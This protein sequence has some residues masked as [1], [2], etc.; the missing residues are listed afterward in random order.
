MNRISS[1]MLNSSALQNLQRSQSDM[2]EAQRKTASGK[3][4]DDLKGYGKDTQAIVSMDRTRAKLESHIEA[5]KELNV[6]LN[7]QDAQIG[8]AADAVADLRE[9]LTTS[10]ALGD[11]TEVMAYVNSAFSDVKSAFNTTFNGSY[12]FG[13]TA[14]NAEPIQADSLADMAANPLTDSINQDGSEVRIRVSESRV[15]TAAPLAKDAATD[16]MNLLR[17]LQ[18]FEDG[19]DGPFTDNPSEA[20]K[21]AIQ[22][23]ILGLDSVYEGML[24]VQSKNGQVMNQTDTLIERQQSQADLLANMTAGMTDADLAQVAVELNQAQIQFQATASI[25]STIQSLSLVDYLR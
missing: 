10:L 6:R 11:L 5:S 16:M 2:Y 3:I 21:Q 1:S 24:E 23:A 18:I 17:D 4:A 20:Q 7:I 13:G 9:N 14:S 8:R 25:F 15:V 19:V 12:V 22:S